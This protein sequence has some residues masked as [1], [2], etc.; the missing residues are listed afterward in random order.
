MK[1]KPI[2]FFIAMVILMV[3]ICTP[4]AI[5]ASLPKVDYIKAELKNAE[6]TTTVSGKIESETEN[7]QT[8]DCSYIISEIIVKSG[9]MVKKGDKIAKIDYEETKSMYEKNGIEY[10]GDEFITADFSGTVNNIYITNGAALTENSQILS[11]IDTDSLRAVLDISEDVFPLI[12]QGQKI[13][14]SGNAL[15]NK[16]YSGKITSIGAV[17]TQTSSS[18]TV[19]ATAKINNADEHLKPGFNIKAK[20]LIKNIK[21][22]LII[23][24]ECILQDDGGE[25]VYKLSNNKS[26]KV[27]IKTDEITSEGTIIK[28]GINEGDFIISNPDSIE[29]DNS[30]VAIREKEND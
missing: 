25:F 27:Y 13:T 12:K 3:S 19:S 20:I 9:D 4:D 21:D 15:G 18:T 6:K 17:A 1:K 16:T 8:A 5:Y 2:F 11:V 7:T 29:K 28:S 26:E 24:S 10:T 22:A 23:P 30:D 14:I